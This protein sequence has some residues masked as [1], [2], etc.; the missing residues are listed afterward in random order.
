MEMWN[1]CQKS[2]LFEAYFIGKNE[3]AF[4]WRT[5]NFLM[6]EARRFSSTEN[7]KIKMQDK[8]QQKYELV[9][10]HDNE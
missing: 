7:Q 4:Y 3:I 8:Q 1:D 2:I 6:N 10:K 9:N 5:E